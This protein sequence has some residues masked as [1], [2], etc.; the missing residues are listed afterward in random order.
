MQIRRGTAARAVGVAVGMAAA[1]AMIFGA[2]LLPRV[3]PRPAMAGAVARPPSVVRSGAAERLATAVRFQTVSEP[4]VRPTDPRAFRELH[5]FLRTAFPRAH[6]VLTRELVGA[7]SLLYTWPG[8]EA[9]AKPILLAAHLDV[10]PVDPASEPAWAYPPFGGVIAKGFVWGRG[11]LDD[12]ASALG[13][14]EAVEHLVAADI[15]PRRTVRPAFPSALAR[16]V[17]AAGACR[18]CPGREH[19]GAT[20]LE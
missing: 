13:L 3:T 9:E 8:R 6:R 11:T 10:V 19:G 1:V 18:R 16:R 2:N 20:R 15:E 4:D 12:K 17:A 14:L 5:E 7:G